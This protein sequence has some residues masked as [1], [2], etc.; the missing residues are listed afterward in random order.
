METRSE[1]RHHFLLDNADLQREIQRQVFGAMTTEENVES[2][3]MAEDDMIRIL[4][5]IAGGS[6][7][8]GSI[9][10]VFM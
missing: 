10:D 5:G 7:Q 4:L 8:F 3:V 6:W 2:E 1:S 9:G